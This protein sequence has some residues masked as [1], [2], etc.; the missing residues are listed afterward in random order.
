MWLSLGESLN[1]A[2]PLQ[3]LLSPR[4]LPAFVLRKGLQP[5]APVSD[6]GRE[7]RGG[8]LWL[9][10]GVRETCL[11]L[12]FLRVAYANLVHS[13]IGS[14]E[15]LEYLFWVTQESLDSD[16]GS[17]ALAFS[18][19]SQ[20]PCQPREYAATTTLAGDPESL[21]KTGAK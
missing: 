14:P 5:G 10:T 4:L 16:L 6:R 13:Q 2:P 18:P 17:L 7:G 9:R 1:P 12:P 19:L 15:M 8:G 21:F 3:T 11:W 20:P